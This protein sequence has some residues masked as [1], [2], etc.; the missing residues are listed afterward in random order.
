MN[1]MAFVVAVVTAD[2]IANP[3]TVSGR[4]GSQG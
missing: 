4:T 1:R 2:Y 3:W